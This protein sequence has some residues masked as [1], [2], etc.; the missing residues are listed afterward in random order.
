MPVTFAIEILLIILAVEL[1]VCWTLFICPLDREDYAPAYLFAP[2][3]ITMMI[4]SSPTWPPMRFW[5]LR[6]TAVTVVWFL[7]GYLLWNQT[8]WSGWKFWPSFLV[9]LPAVWFVACGV[10]VGT[11]GVLYR[12]VT[13]KRHRRYAT[14]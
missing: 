8:N 4:L 7:C 2:F 9:G 5:Q 3:W 12:L 14:F 1:A 6:R 13:E 10:V 11:A